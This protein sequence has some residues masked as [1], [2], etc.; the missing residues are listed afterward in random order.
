M[1]DKTFPIPVDGAFRAFESLFAAEVSADRADLWAAF[2]TLERAIAQ[3]TPVHVERSAAAGDAEVTAADIAEIESAEFVTTLKPARAL[4][5]LK[6]LAREVVVR[7]AMAAPTPVERTS[8]SKRERAMIVSFLRSE[9]E[10]YARNSEEPKH[11]AAGRERCRN[12]A[13]VLRTV[14]AYIE[15][16][17]H[18]TPLCAPPPEV[19]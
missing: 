2:F 5:L 19:A 3:A 12:K 9:E 13:C 10:R 11:D 17:D 8:G 18:E 1:S 16:G 7:R 6:R 14:G 15:R 4:S